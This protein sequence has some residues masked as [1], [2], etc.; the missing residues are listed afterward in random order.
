VRGEA[1]PPYPLAA[2]AHDHLIALAVEESAETDSTVTT[3]VQA[4]G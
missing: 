1:P 4:W 2:G 3:G